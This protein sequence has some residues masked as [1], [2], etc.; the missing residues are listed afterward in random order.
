MSINSPSRMRLG[1]IGTGTITSAI[2]TGLLSDPALAG[3]IVVSPRGREVAARLAASFRDV[4]VG[5][6]N[7]QVLDECDVVFV[8]VRPQVASEV[9]SPLRFESRHRVISLV[10][11]FSRDRIAELVRPAERVCC[12]VPLPMV[13]QRRGPT[14]IFPPDPVAKR[15]FDGLGAGIQVA[16]EPEFQALWASTAAMASYFMVVGEVQSWLE[17]Q[18]VAAATA[19][20][21]AARLFEGLSRVPRES[22]AS[23]A[24]LA[25]EF[26]TRGGLNEQMAA[27]LA[28]CGALK[29]WRT[30]LDEVL[31]RI[32]G[33]GV[34]PSPPR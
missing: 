8:A 18:G 27:A 15:L 6:S 10:A 4:S 7:Q 14:L 21:Y 12:A 9:L 31:V 28:D 26:S 1:F 23:F 19:R 24:E 17:R 22:E 20:E 34:P 2:V 3:S 16:T 5:A 32:R 29:A 33:G 13:A 30:A 11:T 25:G